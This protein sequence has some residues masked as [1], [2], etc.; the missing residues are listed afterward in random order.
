MRALLPTLK[1]AINNEYLNGEVPLLTLEFIHSTISTIYLVKNTEDI[2]SNGITYVAFPFQAK[3][4]DE[5]F[6]TLA[7]VQVTL[8]DLER[9]FIETLRNPNVNGLT[10]LKVRGRVLLASEPNND[11]TTPW[12]WY[13]LDTQWNTQRG[14]SMTLGPRPLQRNTFPSDSISPDA[15]P[16]AHGVTVS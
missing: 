8:Y 7:S 16:A 10:P 15:F 9:Q 1:A 4:L 11:Q 13:L 5:G 6:G 14:V 12:T 2:I 3:L